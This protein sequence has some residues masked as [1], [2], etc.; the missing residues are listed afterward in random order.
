MKTDLPVLGTNLPGIPLFKK[1]KVRDVYDLGQELLL[2]S[3]DRISAFDVVL[4]TGI[5]MKG[6]VLTQLSAF[7]FSKTRDVAASHFVTADIDEVIGRHPKL[8]P[9]REILKGRSTLAAKAEVVPIE[10]VVRG[11]LSGSGWKEY[12]KSQAVCGV[13]LPKGLAESAELPRPIF[14]PATKEETGHD[15]NISEAQM[16]E[17]IGQDLTRQLRERSLGLY[18]LARDHARSRGIL[19]AD[20]KFEFGLLNGKVTLVDEVLTP[21]SS[22]FWPMEEYAPGRPQM[23]FDKQFVRDY[24]ESLAWDKKPPAP[25]LPDEIV[26]KTSAKYLQAYELLTGRSL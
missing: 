10:C 4:P 2:V 23:S 3:T 6:T 17:R 16:A 5:P 22:R 1:G 26:E 9:H 21:D 15:L 19:I 18:S 13:A 20:T 12:Q 14:T 8:K 7:W 24:L 25:A 11:Y